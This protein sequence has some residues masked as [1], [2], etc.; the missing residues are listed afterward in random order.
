MNIGLAIWW[1]AKHQLWRFRKE[2]AGT[3]LDHTSVVWLVPAEPWLL[4]PR[5]R[6]TPPLSH[7]PPAERVE[8]P[9]MKW[10]SPRLGHC[11]SSP[12]SYVMD[13]GTVHP[14]GT[15]TGMSA[16]VILN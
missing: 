8:L 13:L 9:F 10:L 5:I 15:Q 3:Q 1:G 11:R 2:S 6:K 7:G 12:V 16:E 14:T 4:S